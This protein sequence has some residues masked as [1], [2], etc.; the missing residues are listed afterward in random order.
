MNDNS[1]IV[2]ENY[3]L[4]QQ[5]VLINESNEKNEMQKIFMSRQPSAS[6]NNGGE[7]LLMHF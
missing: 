4:N 7:S 2:A 1:Q 3:Y 6:S 5:K